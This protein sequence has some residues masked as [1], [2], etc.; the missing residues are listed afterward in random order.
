MQVSNLPDD[1]LQEE[2]LGDEV[3]DFACVEF[4]TNNPTIKELNTA[5]DELTTTWEEYAEPEYN[6]R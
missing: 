5:L 1:Y 6:Y 2:N 3:F 4:N